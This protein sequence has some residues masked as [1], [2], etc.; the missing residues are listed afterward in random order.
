[1]QVI[2]NQNASCADSF[3]LGTSLTAR[4]CFSPQM[5][6]AVQENIKTEN[7][8]GLHKMLTGMFLST[9]LSPEYNESSSLK[10]VSSTQSL[11]L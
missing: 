4:Y 5:E 10:Q 6:V 7:S 3:L 1:M 9:L 11:C 8:K 2:G